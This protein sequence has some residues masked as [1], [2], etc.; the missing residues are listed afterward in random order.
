MD[1]RASSKVESIRSDLVKVARIAVA[2][3]AGC[4]G[5]PIPDEAVSAHELPEGERADGGA[6]PGAPDAASVPPGSDA[7]HPEQGTEGTSSWRGGARLDCR[8]DPR[9]ALGMVSYDVC[10]GADLFFRETFGGNGRTCASC[11]PANN[12]YTVDPEFI[13]EVPADDPLFVAEYDPSLRQLEKSH[14]LRKLGLFVVNADGF[15]DPT[16]KYVMR[17]VPHMLSMATSIEAL[18][19]DEEGG[20]ALDGT[21][22][23][24]NVRAGWSGDGAP[25]DGALVDFALGAIEQHSPRSLA[26]VEGRDF[27]EPSH[28][29]ADQIAKFTLGLGRTNELDLEQVWLNDAAAERG[30]NSFLT[31]PA[32]DCAVCHQNAGANTP[33]LDSETEEVVLFN[34]NFDVGSDLL[35]GDLLNAEG[36][37]HDGG[38]GRKPRD[39]DGDGKPDVFGTGTFSP[40][41]LIEAADTGPFFHTN[42]FRTIEDA[43]RFYTT[44]EFGTSPNGAVGDP[45]HGTTGGAFQLDEAGIADLGRFLRVLNTAFNAQMAL[46][47]LTAARTIAGRYGEQDLSVQHGL[48]ALADVELEDAVE[49]LSAVPDL[50]VDA[51]HKLSEARAAIAEARSGV[52]SAT[53]ERLAQVAHDAV[54]CANDLLGRGMTYQIGP[55]T[56]MF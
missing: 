36:I 3:L 10:A 33:F 48:L 22:S 37:P 7:A 12:N 53:R 2:L 29:Q 1:K 39:T 30:R 26:R 24:P 21:T 16:N 52:D 50:H 40:P 11:H 23:P 51:Q 14:L 46:A 41:P 5:D 47:R 8:R 20:V 25:G 17:S 27:H 6:D 35:R 38:F 31:G 9:V 54:T 43:V 56:L 45:E 55:A 19:A 42:A 28:E 32:K 15:E 49:V 34:V 44:D 18:P 4:G 13:A